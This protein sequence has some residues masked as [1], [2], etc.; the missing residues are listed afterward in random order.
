MEV[1]QEEQ[2]WE[3]A[4]ENCC[5]ALKVPGSARKILPRGKQVC[6]TTTLAVKY[7]V[8]PV[9]PN[10][11]YLR[12]LTTTQ[13]DAVVTKLNFNPKSIYSDW[14]ENFVS[15]T[16]DHICC[17]KLDDF[18]RL[19]KAI[20][21]TALIKNKKRHEKDDS[22][23]RAG[24]VNYVLGWDNRDKIV[25]LQREGN[26]IGAELDALDKKVE[27]LRSNK[28]IEDQA[29]ETLSRLSDIKDY[30]LIDWKTTAKSIS[31][32]E[33]EKK[34][35]LNKNSDLNALEKKLTERTKLKDG[36]Q[37]LIEKIAGDIRIKEEKANNLS[38]KARQLGVTIAE[39]EKLTDLK[40]LFAKYAAQLAAFA[41][42]E[43]EDTEITERTA[44]DSMKTELADLNTDSQKLFQIISEAMDKY[45]RPSKEIQEKFPE[46]MVETENLKAKPEYLKE[47][48]DIYKNL[49]EEKIA[50][51]EKRFKNEL[52]N[53]VIKDLSS[54]QNKLYEQ[55]SGINESV[56]NINRSLKRIKFNINPDTYIQL[57]NNLTRTPEIADFKKKLKEW[58]PN[59][60]ELALN[61]ITYL[62]EHF[63]N[64][65]RPFIEE[66][67]TNDAWRKRVTDVR[68]WMEFKATEH[69]AEDNQI[70][71]VYES[72]GSLSGGQAAQLTYTILGSAIAHQFGINQSGS[73]AR[74][75]RF[76]VVDEA[77][78]KLDPEKSKYLMELCKQLHL[79]LMV[80]TPLDKIHVVEE[81]VSV[82]HYVE[83]KS[84]RNS[85]VVDMSIMEYKNQRK[86]KS[87]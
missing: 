23:N 33:E 54:F 70:S 73:T 53:S 31:E 7:R 6:T 68:N 50:E 74:S 55:E 15:H 34:Q 65:I 10:Q 85:D 72:S 57:Q 8:L 79:Q 87:K 71:N 62:E 28:D 64:V 49:K 81:Y 19:E 58:V 67:Q 59:T 29:L 52:N 14:A 18:A 36:V 43:D 30:T 12:S 63:S 56:E 69:F 78:S 13:T 21:V 4:I 37:T 86:S 26:K 40:R 5:I 66:L 45:L 11:D 9:D 1:K 51:F 41:T 32:R 42:T 75:F 22:K 61:N 44:L 84:K 77:F 60:K 47:F 39:F 48:V 38:E 46:W 17:E 24:A 27:N 76:I 25:A 80:V 16:Y 2:H 82:I 3:V 83:N 20:T 35:L